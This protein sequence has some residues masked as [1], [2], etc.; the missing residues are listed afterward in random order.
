MKKGL[1]LFLLLLSVGLISCK[2]DDAGEP[3]LPEEDFEVLEGNITQNLS[4][5]ANKQYLLRGKV[6][7]Q[8]PNTLTIPAGTVIFGEKATDG[9]LIINRGAKIMAEGTATNPI[10]FTSQAAP[11]FR[12]R[13]DWGG[14]VVLGNAQTNNPANSPIEG[15]SA[16]GSENGIYGPG[17]GAAQNEQNSGVMKFVR[18]EYAG[19]DLSQ[20]NELNSLTMGALGSGTTI[21][22]IMVSYANDDAYEWF[23]GTV[24][25]KYLIAYNTLDDDFDSDRGYTGRVQYG[26]VVRFPGIADVSTSRA[27]EASSNNDASLPLQS[28]PSF[29]NITVLGPRMFSSSVSGSYGA[30]VEINSNSSMKL[31][32]SIISGFPIGIRYNG[33]GAE[34]MVMNNVFV[35][36]TTLS[37]TS[38]GSSVPAT[39]ESSN[40]VASKEA[41]FGE[42]AVFNSATPSPLLLPAGSTYAAGAPELPAGFEQ[43]GFWGAFGSSETDT[44]WNLTSGWIEWNPGDAQY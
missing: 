16:T 13:G 35:E 4:L 2:D 12:N 11:G 3:L 10:V 9:T 18:I 44:D 8:A 29:A 6:Y 25:H 17:D 20:D 21:E 15:I 5:D 36:N 1:Y 43:K 34:A 28:A 19:I 41:V 39:F 38:G 42:G 33:S 24:N 40:Q 37:S 22:H 27:F 23:G 14:V 31:H 7:V 32:N 30:A 26:L